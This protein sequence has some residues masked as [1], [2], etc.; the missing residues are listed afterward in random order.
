MTVDSEVG[1]GSAFTVTVPL[2]TTHLPPT[3]SR[4]RRPASARRVVQ[5]DAFVQE[6][7]RW[8]PTDA[9]RVPSRSA[10]GRTRSAARLVGSPVDARRSARRRGRRQRGHARVS[11]PDPRRCS[12]QVE[13]VRDGA[14][15]L[16]RVRS[17]P[18]DLV[19]ADVMMPALDGFGLLAAI[20]SDEQLRIAAG[21]AAV[22]ARRRGGAHRGA[23]RR[24]RRL[25]GQAVQRPRAA[26]VRGVAAEAGARA[27]WR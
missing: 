24:R 3:A 16:E 22:G 12:Y 14:A 4:W 6:A 13:A 8:L 10:P 25:H 2:G 26:R 20:R 11:Q 18:P 15:A 9:H 1:R 5:A 27:P 23:G 21:G 7:S 17:A 19:L